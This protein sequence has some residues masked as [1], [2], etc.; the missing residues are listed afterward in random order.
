[1]LLQRLR[2]YGER[3]E[4]ENPTPSMYIPTS[5]RY[6]VELDGSGRYLGL[7]DLKDPSSPKGGRGRQMLAPTVGKTSGIKAKLLADTAEYVL[8]VARNPEKQ[9]RVDA[10]HRAFRALLQHC[11]RAT[12]HPTLHAIES[13]LD[14]LDVSTLE[15]ADDFDAGGVVT[16]RVDG[17]YPI[18]LPE[19]RQFWAT[20]ALREADDD[21][22]DGASSPVMQCLVCNRERPAMERLPLKI[23]GIR[24]GQTSGLALISANAEAFESYGLTA[25]LTA[26]TCQSCSE[27]FSKGLN[28][29]LS[30]R[31]THISV[32]D[33]TYVFWTREPVADFSFATM[34][35]DADDGQVRALFD[36]ARRGTSGATQLDVTP[37]YAAALSASGARVVVRDWLDTTVGAAQVN[38]QRYFQLQNLVDPYGE[39]GNPQKLFALAAA[40]VRDANKETLVHAAR[41]L[42]RLA[43]GGGALPQGMLFQAVRRN[44]AEQKV[45]RQRAVLIKMVLSSTLESLED[46]AMVE[47]NDSNRDPAYLCGRLLAVLER[48]Q[49]TALPNLN[50]TI[51][52]RFFGSAST[53]PASVF[54]RLLRGGQPHLS[55]L[56]RDRPGAYFALQ[57]RLEEILA[58]LQSFPRTLNLEQQGLFALGYYHQR[59]ADRSGARARKEAKQT[60]QTTDDESGE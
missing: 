55:K 46:D 39:P 4:Q 33:L 16:F 25:S 6:Q 13:F 42:L 57:V 19:V 27:R 21:S 7:I 35:S 34:L 3:L 37:F 12:Q 59:A 56:R 40:T 45:T 58:G 2:D 41:A 49:M 31:D 54:S 14:E 10:C 60:P 23:K 51:V 24:G 11:I 8:G 5:I 48:V 22:A 28:L 20:N 36:S 17:T 30:E 18:D 26:P 47:L 44:R 50:A 9:E 38:L 15:L 32:G 52:D 43:L 1:M 53:A 29:L